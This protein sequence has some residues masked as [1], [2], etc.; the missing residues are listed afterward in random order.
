M[1]PGLPLFLSDLNAIHPF[2]EGNGRTQSTLLALVADQAG[3]P[4]DL[5]RLNP[6]SMLAAMITSFS[7]DEK[8]LAA[9]IGRL[10][11]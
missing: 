8:A 1:H 7:T 2:R 4:L 10:I 11:A 5:D 6:G 3:H 9:M